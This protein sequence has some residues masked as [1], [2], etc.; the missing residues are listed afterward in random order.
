MTAKASLSKLALPVDPTAAL[1]A[2]TKQY[3]D[4]LTL[5]LGEP[6]KGPARPTKP[7]T[8]LGT[9][10]QHAAFPGTCQLPDGTLLLSWR[11]GS[12]HVNA[13]DGGLMIARSSD[14]GRTWTTPATLI[15]NPGS[16]VD[17]RDP[18]L[19][20][21][22]DG[23]RVYLTYFKATSAAPAN[24][25]F[26]RTST[27]GGLNWGSEK[28]IDQGIPVVICAP[29]VE[30]TDGT[31]VAPLYGKSTTGEAFESVWTAR[32]TDQGVTWAAATRL[33]DGVAAGRDYQEP[34]GV[35]RFGVM[36]MFFRWGNADGI[37]RIAATNAAAT[38]W[39]TP[40]R[41]FTGSGRP[42]WVWLTSGAMVLTYR[43]STG[44]SYMLRH[45]IDGGVSWQAPQ[46][47]ARASNA[48][49]WCYT[50]PI[51]VA[52]NEL[53]APFSYQ[54]SAEVVAKIY[55]QYLTQGG[56]DTPLGSVPSEM[57]S[58]LDDYERTAIA[59]NFMQVDGVLDPLVWNNFVG[60]ISVTDG[61]ASST[62]ADGTSD[63]AVGIWG[64][65]TN[66]QEIMAEMY[67]LAGSGNGLVFRYINSTNY[68]LVQT[69]AAPRII[70]YKIVAGVATGLG[71]ATYTQPYGRFVKWRLSAV[72]DQ[73]NVWIDE[74]KVL[75]PIT[76]PSGDVTTFALG[77]GA[78]IIMNSNTTG[79][80]VHR[81]RRFIARDA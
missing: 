4:R 70:V 22:V 65:G 5:Q 10:T 28:R 6:G 60:G 79:G 63:R 27:D 76:I 43:A 78:G 16:G 20:V 66:D 55:L 75:G 57:E 51:E 18:S 37:G 38:T 7:A 58:I 23:K 31:L 77:N 25:A 1:D 15:A 35:F 2:V 53:F 67:G 73:L 29:L 71:N 47:I 45:S 69:E 34:W 81:C 42:S 52:P 48:G 19:S 32:S 21:S 68:M 72:G 62:T 46:T 33:I 3:V 39:E 54:D 36:V 12:N 13:R 8:P 49:M 80:I 64:T 74:T 11:V 61:V 41:R 50:S 14:L 56:G 26:M 30:L 40:T 9:D 24:G 44:G 59:S 17:L